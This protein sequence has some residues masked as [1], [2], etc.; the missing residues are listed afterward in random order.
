MNAK[1]IFEVLVQ[2]LLSERNLQGG[3]LRAFGAFNKIAGF[4]RR[5]VILLNLSILP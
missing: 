1:N 4:I 5:T 2:V 3:K